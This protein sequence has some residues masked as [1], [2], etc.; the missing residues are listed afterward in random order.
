MPK[1]PK[2]GERTKKALSRKQ[3][4]IARVAKPRKKI[5]AADLKKLRARKKKK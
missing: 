4:K 3:K 5:T 2:R 1:L